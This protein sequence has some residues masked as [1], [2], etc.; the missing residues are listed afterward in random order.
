MGLDGH[1]DHTCWLLAAGVNR[2]AGSPNWQLC[3]MYKPSM[4]F[5]SGGSS[6]TS[7]WSRRVSHWDEGQLELLLSHRVRREHPGSDHSHDSSCVWKMVLSTT[8]GQKYAVLFTGEKTQHIVLSCSYLRW[9]PPLFVDPWQCVGGLL[10]TEFS[11]WGKY[12]NL[13]L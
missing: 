13:C 7:L 1:R 3:W 5:Y 4:G 2:G 6:W 10:E 11:W 9:G 12:F 8:V